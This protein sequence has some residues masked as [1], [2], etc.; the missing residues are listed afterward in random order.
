MQHLRSL[1]HH[2]NAMRLD[3]F[4]NR[5]GDLLR[6]AFLHLQPP[7]VHLD[8]TRE[9]AQTEYLL[10]GQISDRDLLLLYGEKTSVV[11]L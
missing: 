4:G 2:S 6:Q 1:N 10:V 8:N 9:L 11:Q 5:I 7:T 3:R